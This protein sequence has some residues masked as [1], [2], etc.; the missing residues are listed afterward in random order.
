MTSDLLTKLA[1]RRPVISMRSALV[2]AASIVAMIG[3]AGYSMVVS[4]MHGEVVDRTRKNEPHLLDDPSTSAFAPSEFRAYLDWR[5]WRIGVALEWE[6]TSD[7][8]RIYRIPAGRSK[9]IQSDGRSGRLF[10]ADIVPGR[11]HWYVACVLVQGQEYCSDPIVL[12]IP[13]GI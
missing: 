4:R 1:M 13:A 11:V 2:V 9:Y 12:D 6:P 7:E 10:D 3:V 5:D 8:V